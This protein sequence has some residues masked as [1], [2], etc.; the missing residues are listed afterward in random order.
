MKKMLKKDNPVY[1]Y[2]MDRPF[3]VATKE[4]DL[5]GRAGDWL[6]FDPLSGHTWPVAAYYVALHYSEAPDAA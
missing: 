6:A 3:K 1:M 2:Q 4:G 5:D